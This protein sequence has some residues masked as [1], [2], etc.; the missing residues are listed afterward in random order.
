MKVLPPDRS[1]AAPHRA[2]FDNGVAHRLSLFGSKTTHS[3]PPRNDVRG[4]GTGVAWTR[5]ANETTRAPRA[6]VTPNAV[7]V[8]APL[9]GLPTTARKKEAT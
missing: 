9:P 2:D 8:A 4:R 5:I 7:V 3:T 1:F 6:Y